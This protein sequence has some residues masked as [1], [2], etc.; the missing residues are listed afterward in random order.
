MRLV[1]LVVLLALAPGC[2]G[3]GRS[4]NPAYAADAVMIGV[5]GTLAL[6]LDGKG[7]NKDGG[8]AMMIAG[9]IGLAIT[10]F[11]STIAPP[12]E[13]AEYGPAYTVALILDGLAMAVGIGLVV[14]EELAFRDADPDDVDTHLGSALGTLTIIGAA[15]VGLGIETVDAATN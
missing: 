12:S 6:T 2:V 14:E 5:G 11:I 13:T 7:A 9:L 3:W 1:T 10:G 15:L 4:R 8:G